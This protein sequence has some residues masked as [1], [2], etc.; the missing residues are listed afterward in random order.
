MYKNYW[1]KKSQVKISQAKIFSSSE[2]QSQ[3]SNHVVLLVSVSKIHRI[4]NTIAEHK[5]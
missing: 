5:Q 3:A 2:A 4:T 1:W